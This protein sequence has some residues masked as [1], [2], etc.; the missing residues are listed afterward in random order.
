MLECIRKQIG[1]KPIFITSGYRTQEENDTIYPK[2]TKPTVSEH[3]IMA[4]VDISSPVGYEKLKEACEMQYAK[5]IVGGLGT[6]KG[7]IHVGARHKIPYKN[8]KARWYYN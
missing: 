2:K 8:S 7:I 3:I 6:G 5:D 1:D 4:G